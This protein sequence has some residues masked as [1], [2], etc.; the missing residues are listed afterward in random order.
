MTRAALALRSRAPSHPPAA[1][2]APARPALPISRP[3]D[4][5]EQEADRA[6]DRV[7][8]GE[9]AGISAAP[10][11]VARKCAGCAEE[12]REAEGEI[13]RKPLADGPL[14]G[15]APPAVA[16]ALA[17]P[18]RPLDAESLAYFQPR[19]RTSFADVRIHDDG[20]ADSAAR[21]IDA[22]AFT[23]GRRIAFA[24]GQYAPREPAGRRLLAHELAHAVQQG[25]EGRALQRD[26]VGTG[27]GAAPSGPGPAPPAGGGAAA[28]PISVDVLS[29]QDPEDFLV[30]AAAQT[31][32]VDIRVRSLTDMIGRLAG[33]ATG[34]SC[35]GRVR[36]FNHANPSHQ[37][38][39]GGSKVKTPGAAPT[40]SPTEGF[41]LTWLL[42]NA[43]QADLNRFRGALCCSPEM[44]WYGCST[45]G[46]WAEGG[47]RT[48]AELTG[49]ERYEGTSGQLYHSVDDA[50]AHG[51]TRFRSIGSQNVQ[52]W[53]NALCASITASTDFNNW[54][55]S[56]GGTVTRTVIYGGR[57]LLY[58]PQSDSAC[59]CDSATGRLSGAAP[60]AAQ[61]SARSD[62]LREYYLAPVRQRATGRLGTP[63]PPRPA[64]TPAER[65]ARERTEASEVA[66]TA[67]LGSRMRD[68]VLQGALLA[69]GAAPA[70]P[71]E[72]IRVT[73]RWGLD[74][75]TIVRRLPAQI[76]STAQQ[77]T[78]THTATTL[79]QD[80]RSA[81]DALTP[82]L[83]ETFYSALLLVQQ[84]SFWR[85]YLASH[86]VYMIPDV[87]GMDY[88]GY[89][90]TGTHTDASG[91]VER[92]YAIHMSI[93][94]LR[95]GDARRVAAT[96]VHELS[97]QVDRP[98]GSP[99]FRPLLGELAALIASHPDIVALRAGAPDPALAE[100]RQLRSIN[101]MLY[102]A[103]SR[104]EDE[105]FV[106]LQQLTHQPDMTI[107]GTRVRAG[108]YIIT[109]IEGFVRQLRTIG[110][111]AAMVND[112]LRRVFARAMRLYD[113]RIAAA[114][115]GSR[116]RQLLEVNKQLAGLVWQ[117]ALRFAATP[118][119]TP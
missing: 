111:P 13:R 108:D 118:P 70:T 104:A 90:Q 101:Q 58:R 40:Q 115:A 106:H 65:Q 27:S 114:P 47:S 30:R 15:R 99:A 75:A 84:E 44:N 29:A 55:T 38:V 88:G 20:P 79:G 35:V 18:G 23:Y 103:T 96:M 107:G 5:A 43:H 10:P 72:A 45:A 116:E 61:L 57:D 113:E 94:L 49:G 2:A 102:E 37:A 68:S 14:A 91:R 6:A 83:R 98:V 21:A 12:D 28:R 89:T 95:I 63:Q 52:S 41:S 34:N 92:T 73:S 117:E 16:A 62:S 77:T 7:L 97:H 50:L 53:S 48:A 100:R 33:L 46:V 60:T 26:A 85:N 82:A 36:V 119:A 69:P 86:T 71:L 110:L 112:L 4:W 74:L 56:R 66:A 17:A 67:A 19:F 3:G 109:L 32:G 51:A 42:D 81:I 105:I 31:L 93:E 76:S 87:T 59:A 78:G 64:E 11:G 8:R 80:Q 39:V 1:G 54:H 25:G 9:S 22:R 24:A